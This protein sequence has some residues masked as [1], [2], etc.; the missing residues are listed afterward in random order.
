MHIGNSIL[1]PFSS[2]PK[3]ALAMIES[4]K[5]VTGISSFGL[6]TPEGVRLRPFLI[7]S[8]GS[9]LEERVVFNGFITPLRAR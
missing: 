5:N 7:E 9:I 3:V 1:M 6:A 8:G 2:T 4:T